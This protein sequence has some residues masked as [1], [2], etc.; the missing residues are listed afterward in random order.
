VSLRCSFGS[1]QEHVQRCAV[2][3]NTIGDNC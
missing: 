3:V 2:Q 1:R